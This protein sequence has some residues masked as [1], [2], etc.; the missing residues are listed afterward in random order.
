MMR[1]RRRSEAGAIVTHAQHE[2]VS[3]PSRRDLHRATFGALRDAVSERVLDDGLQEEF[4]HG[5]VEQ[6]AVD[7]E[8]HTKAIG[9]AHLLNGQVALEKAKLRVERDL[10]RL[11]AA[12]DLA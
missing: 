6:I 2:G 5:G 11:V 9:E 1:A 10:V 12:Q 8:A 3:L 4:G 7:I